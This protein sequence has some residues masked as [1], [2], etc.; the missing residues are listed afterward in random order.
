MTSSKKEKKF[1]QKK[2]ALN[3][4]QKNRNYFSF[5]AKNPKIQ[6]N[7]EFPSIQPACL[8]AFILPTLSRGLG[9][10]DEK[11]L[12][13][14]RTVAI[15][16]AK[17]IGRMGWAIHRLCP[18]SIIICLLWKISF[19]KCLLWKIRFNVCILQKIRFKKCLLQ[20]IRFKICLL[21]KISFKKCNLWKIRFNVCILQKI[22]FK[23]CL[24]QKIRFKICLLKKIEKIN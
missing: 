22:S 23:N 16:N 18:I 8:A 24:L 9:S 19:K 11:I 17:L 13:N 7:R 21:W 1:R 5:P 3:F 10:S 15:G 4:F 2:N 6:P 20:K 14:H 12:A